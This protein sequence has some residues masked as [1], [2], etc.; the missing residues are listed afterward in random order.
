[1]D[2]VTFKDVQDAHQ[3]IKSYIKKTPVVFSK[4][5]SKMLGHSIFF[6][7]ENTQHTGSFKFRGALYSVLK[8]KNNPPKSIVTYGTG[9]HAVALAW[10]ASKILDIKITAY[11]TDFTSDIKKQLIQEYGAKTI[12]TKTREEAEKQALQESQKNGTILLPPSDNDDVIAGAATVPLEALE[13]LKEEMDAIFIPIG[14]G[15]LSSGT[16]ITTNSISPN[17]KIYGAEPESGND[18]LI[19]IKNKKIHAL[20]KSPQTLADGAK[21][22]KISKRVFKYIQK[23]DDIYG[24]TEHEIEYWTSWFNHLEISTD[25]CEPTSSLAIA[26]AARWLKAQTKPKKVLVIITGRNI[27]DSTYNELAKSQHLSIIPK[28]SN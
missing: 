1:M 21:T 4:K 3:T 2:S 9:N 26:A 20:S 24:I 13:Q 18:A 10:A 23:I 8:L 11:L 19:S 27:N 16:I 5:L 25:P 22:Q 6:K 15:S 7:L 14:G 17:T 28:H 12:F